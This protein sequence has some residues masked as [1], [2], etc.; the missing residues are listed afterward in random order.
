MCRAIMSRS[1]PAWARR[2][3]RTSSCCRS[4]SKARSRRSWSF[5]RSSNSARR[6]RRS[7]I[8]L[9]ES[10]GIVL[11]TIEANTRTEDLLKQSQSLAAEL[12]SRQ[13]ELQKTNQ[14]L[15]EKAQAALRA[16]R[17]SRT[18]EPRSRTGPAGARRKGPAAL[19]HF[20]VQ[21]RVPRQHVPRV[22][23]AAQ[24]P[25]HSRRS[26]CLKPGRQPDRQAGRIRPDHP[27]FRQR[28]AQADQRHSGSLE[29]RVRH[30]QRRRR[31]GAASRNC[32]K[33]DTQFR[34]HVAE[35]KGG[36]FLQ[37]RGRSVCL[38]RF[39]PTR[40]GWSRS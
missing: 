19:A 2:R 15:E 7:S 4:S 24:Q 17:G 28:P 9:T 13:E 33:M 3:R 32:A 1:A 38:R 8:S 26:T 25:A 14:E 21:V 10:I 6:T 27:W 29:D 40:S 5:L 31:R 23:H 16:E 37:H 30:G 34:A 18:Q 12:Q 39:R 11:N 20:Q 36:S 22:A 35:T